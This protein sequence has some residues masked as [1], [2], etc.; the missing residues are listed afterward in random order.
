LKDFFKNIKNILIIILIIIILIIR[1]CSGN[2]NIKT[3]RL[4][5]PPQLTKVEVSYDTVIVVIEKYI[6]KWKEKIVTKI[7]TL[8]FPIDTLSILKDYYTKYIYSDTI[9]IDTIGYAIIN[10][11]ISL[12]TIFSRDIKTNFSIPTTTVTNTIYINN[13]EWYWGLGLAGKIDQI[14]YLGG[15]IL[16][17]TKNKQI[18]GFGIGINQQLQPI[19]S[20]RMY[21]KIGK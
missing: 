6:P 7:D 13:R 15:E 1:N 2:N 9:K 16:L 4:P 12:N 5:N 21:W 3:N 11:V 20:G 19:L 18:Y 14:N 17:K 10:D 8:S